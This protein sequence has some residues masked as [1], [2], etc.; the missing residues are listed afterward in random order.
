[1]AARYAGLQTKPNLQSL[2]CLFG[3]ALW[4]RLVY[5]IGSYL[6]CECGLLIYGSVN[7]YAAS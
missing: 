2:P 3:Y 6:C 5:L 1:M 7:I 4:R